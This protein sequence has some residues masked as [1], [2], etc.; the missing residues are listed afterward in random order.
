MKTKQKRATRLILCCLLVAVSLFAAEYPPE[1]VQAKQAITGKQ[2]VAHIDFLASDY[3]RGRET[4]DIGM[5]VAMKY[6][7]TI[8]KGAAVSPA[9]EYGSYSQRVDLKTID[10]GVNNRFEIQSRSKG[11]SEHFF[12][13]LEWDF[14]PVRLSAEKSVTAPVVFAGY[15]ITAPEHKFDDY[16]GVDASGKVVLVM[17]H[18]PGEKD[19]KSVFEGRKLS[20]Y[21]SLL[22]KILNAQAHGAVGILFVNDPN[23][24]D[25]ME[26]DNVDGTSW[27]LLRAKAYEDD[28]D[29]RFMRFRP[30]TR[31]V[32]DDF[33]VNIPVLAI[34]GKVAARLLGGPEV[35]QDKQTQI[36]DTFKSQSLQ[37][38][39][40][41]VTMEA[42][43]FSEPLDAFNLI[44]K[45]EGSDPD[46][47]H[48][49]VMVGA[50]YDHEG[51]DNR[52]RV[53]AGADDNA[54]GTSGVIE[55]A[56]AF[57]SLPE[58]PKRT[59]V[60]ILFTAEEKGL[61]GSR[62]YVENP[63]FPLEKT[64]AYINL[65]MIGRNDADQISLI[66]R[67]QYPKLYQVIEKVNTKTVN[68]EIYFSV[69]EYIRQSDHFPFMKKNVPSIFF[70]S[71]NHDQLHRPE[72]TAERIVSEKI[73]KV[74]QMIFLTLWDL[75]NLPAGSDLREEAK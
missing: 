59:L 68:M 17:R 41:T 45:V 48:E 14:L 70:N 67:Y 49:I 46:L 35:L 20:K 33:G 66:G 23:N 56:R 9:G 38:K 13:E 60:F 57:Q 15:G 43:F 52:G 58:K 36:D 69:E 32:G 19:P 63:V 53:Y 3:C 25:D 24:H 37:L 44:A 51:K 28:E 1:L 4:G 16:K 18:E 6:L 54:S 65:D 64:L 8:L 34:D 31:I 47:K 73:E 50:H 62:F 2:L 10:L 75:A 11:V 29:F 30:R 40:K 5:E 22:S 21:G 39:D 42:D 12:G 26:A 72:D 7:S 27:A 71:G 55:L 74:T 61:L